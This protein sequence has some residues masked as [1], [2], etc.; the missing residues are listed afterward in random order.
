MHVP[1][2]YFRCYSLITPLGTA[3][4]NNIDPPIFCRETLDPRI[5]MDA[6]RQKPSTQTAFQTKHIPYGT[7]APWWH[8]SPSRT[9]HAALRHHRA[10]RNRNVT[11]NLR[12]APDAN[13]IKLHGMCSPIFCAVA[14]RGFAFDETMFGWVLWLE[15]HPCEYQDLLLSPRTLCWNHDQCHSRHQ[16]ATP[17]NTHT[18]ATF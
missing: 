1:T 14:T 15:K 6:T 2:W 12:C 8:W 5:H 13:L 17:P 10:L 18:E 7:C 11:K 3:G 9:K 16:A 4:K